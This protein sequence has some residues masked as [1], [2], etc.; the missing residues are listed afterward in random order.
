[1]TM[2]KAR[3]EAFSDGVFAIAATLLVLDLHVEAAPGQ[4]ASALAHEWPQYATFVTSFLTIGII[5]VNHHAQFE[6]IARVDRP[7]L[8]LNLLLLMF[9]VL[10]PF[11]TELL[12]TYL[13]AGSDQH[14]AAAAYCGTLLAMGLAFAASWRYVAAHP[15]LLTHPIGAEELAMLT[16]RNAV[17]QGLYVVALG[18]SFISAPLALALCAA[19]AI[20]YV[21]PGRVLTGRRVEP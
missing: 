10:I 15:E 20:Y 17:G 19:G 2:S 7:L 6:R 21:L 1:M 8:F 3:L 11:P 16:R 9:V 14:V 12:A 13:H 4:L 5:W 18:A